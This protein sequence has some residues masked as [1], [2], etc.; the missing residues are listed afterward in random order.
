MERYTLGQAFKADQ[1]PIDTCPRLVQFTKMYARYTI[2]NVTLKAIGL[3]GSA[4]TSS[5]SYGIMS[6]PTDSNVTDPSVLKPSRTHHCAKN[7]SISINRSIQVQD[8]MLTTGKNDNTPFTLYSKTTDASTI[9]MEVHYDITF[10]SPVPFSK[11]SKATYTL[12]TLS[13]PVTWELGDYSND[14]DELSF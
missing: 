8:F 3:A 11:P 5:V 2:N 4:S 12:P 14:E 9:S 7:S 13:A 6:G 1:F 10:S